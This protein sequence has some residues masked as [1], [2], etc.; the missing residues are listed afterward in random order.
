MISWGGRIA[1]WCGTL[2]NSKSTRHAL[3]CYNAFAWLGLYAYATFCGALP[4]RI[5][6]KSG[7]IPR[8]QLRLEKLRPQ[9]PQLIGSKADRGSIS[10][11]CLLL[12]LNT[13][14]VS[15]RACLLVTVMRRCTRGHPK[16]ALMSRCEPRAISFR[17][18]NQLAKSWPGRLVTP[19]YILASAEALRLL[20]WRRSGFLRSIHHAD[21]R[22][23]RSRQ[24]W[25][26]VRTKWP[27]AEWQSHYT[28]TMW[29]KGCIVNKLINP[30]FPSWLLKKSN[31][32][33]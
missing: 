3:T 17:C 13:D 2:S 25:L 24:P 15:V 8:V 12:V 1:C 22:K 21:S 19:P 5:A 18:T 28:C 30:V 26:A 10:S 14:V 31:I 23:R 29:P 32:H 7:A 11:F 9:H 6:A 27:M 20:L 16:L 33:I 4:A